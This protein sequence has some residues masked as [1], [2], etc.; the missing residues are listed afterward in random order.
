MFPNTKETVVLPIG[1]QEVISLLKKVTLPVS[2]VLDKTTEG[3]M[4]NGSF[5]GDTFTISRKIDYPQNYLPLIKG[6]VEDTGI[7]SIIFLEYE[8]FF[9]SKM[10]LTF[11]SVLSVVASLFL[12]LLQGKAN[13]AIASIGIGLINYLVTLMNFKKQ[14][15]ESKNV[16]LSALKLE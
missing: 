3:I 6:R 9:S 2:R 10:F 16:L 8:L 5:A 13:F 4:F 12:L 1:A 7:G 15:K 14:V 11:W